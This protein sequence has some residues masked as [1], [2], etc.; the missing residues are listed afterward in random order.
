M[1]TFNN[2]TVGHVRNLEV[3]DTFATAIVGN[4]DGGTITHVVNSPF[5]LNDEQGAYLQE[6]G[7]RVSPDENGPITSGRYTLLFGHF[8]S[9]AG[10]YKHMFLDYDRVVAVFPKD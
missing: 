5:Q 8:H 10:P 2:V 6:K 9:V 3:G 7:I 1:H 4:M